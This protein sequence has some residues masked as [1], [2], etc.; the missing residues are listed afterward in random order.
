MLRRDFM[1]AGT[2]LGVLYG[3]G[4]VP[5]RTAR[6]AQSANFD[7]ATVRTLAHQLSQQPYQPPSQTLPSALRNLNFDQY[8]SIAFR[9]EQ[10]L[11]HG[12]N[13]GF[14]VE[15]FPRGYLYAPRI[16]M[17]EVIDGQSRPIAFNADMFTYNDPAL[18]VS[19]DI[20]FAG[21]RLRAPINTP[22]VMEEFCVFLGASYFRAVAKGQTYGCP[23][24]ALPMAPATRR[25][26][27][28]P[29][30]APSGWKSPRQAWT[31]WLSMPCWT[32][33][34]WPVRS[35]LPSAGRDNGL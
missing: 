35:A 1:K 32:A 18:R 9:S 22:G 31:A 7:S 29:C 4:T 24:V 17:N 15:F 13:L 26:K 34:H 30:S 5:V 11:W 23:R 12:E 20:G 21:L 2:A 3:A 16:D 19:E 14:D 33:R 25:V 6:A 28:S 27:N 10:A 8:N